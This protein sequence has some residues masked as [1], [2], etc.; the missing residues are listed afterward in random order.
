MDF[1]IKPSLH[2]PKTHCSI[3]PA[4]QY[5]NWDEAPKFLLIK[6]IR[7]QLARLWSVLRKNPPTTINHKGFDL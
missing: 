6:I 4:F 3:I 7:S 2:H 5:S 1:G